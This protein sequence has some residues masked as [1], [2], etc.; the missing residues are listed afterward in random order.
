MLLN[1]RFI[2]SEIYKSLFFKEDDDFQTIGY[3]LLMF[4]IC[5][6]ILHVDDG[7]KEL[8]YFIYI[9]EIAVFYKNSHITKTLFQ[10]CIVV[11]LF[12]IEG[13]Q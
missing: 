4:G 5:Q 13:P 9:S 12:K 7:Y 8:Q 11:A 10:C 6:M 3:I 1:E 2:I